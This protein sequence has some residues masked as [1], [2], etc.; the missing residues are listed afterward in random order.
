V[1]SI[2]LGPLA[3]PV[4]PLLLMGALLAASTLADRL[5]PAGDAAGG[6]T[7]RR[8]GAGGSILNAALAAFAAA[9]LVH[10][11]MNLP[12]YLEQPWAM[13]DLRDG[14]WHAPAGVAAGL[15]WIAWE[16]W[17][18]VAWRK[19]LLAGAAL[20]CALSGIGAYMLAARTPQ[21]L[22]DLVLTNLADGQP[23]RLRELAAQRPVVLNLWA[24]WC[25]PCRSEMPVLAAAESRHR[26]VLFVFVNQGEAAG[27]ARRYLDTEGLR[28]GTVLLDPASQ[29]GPAVGSRGLPTTVFYDR[30]GRRVDAH[31]GVLNGAALAA[32][33]KPLLGRPG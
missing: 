16:A 23:V 8:G 15:A 13:L 26:D 28:L 33:L 27:A 2:S 30:E 3:L 9:R 6:G 29:V 12:A 20:G 25:G 7:R 18:H 17:R 10:V 32:R 19:A 11:G 31:L 1:T 14:G 22:P 4:M 5:T 21:Q 24:S